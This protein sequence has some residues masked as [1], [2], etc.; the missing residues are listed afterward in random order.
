MSARQLR[1][2]N[3]PRRVSWSSPVEMD[4]GGQRVS[5]SSYYSSSNHDSSTSSRSFSLRQQQRKSGKH[6]VDNEDDDNSSICQ[7]KKKKEKQESKERYLA[8]MLSLAVSLLIAMIVTRVY[9]FSIPLGRNNFRLGT[10]NPILRFRE[11]QVETT[12]KYTYPE[13]KF[14]I[15]QLADLHLGESTAK[16]ERTYKLIDDILKQEYPVDLIV[17]SGDQISAEYCGDANCGTDLYYE[18][19]AFL[20][21]YRIPW[22]VVFGDT[23]DSKTKGI[24]RQQLLNIDQSFEY[25]LSSST[26][27]TPYNVRNLGVAQIQEEQAMQLF[28]TTN[29]LLDIYVPSSIDTKLTSDTFTTSSVNAGTAAAQIYFFDSGGGSL[30]KQLEQNQVSWFLHTNQ[31]L[32]AIAFQHIPTYNFR[33]KTEKCLGYHDAK[34]DSMFDFTSS[35]S[36]ANND[37]KRSSINKVLDTIEYDPGIADAMSESTRISFLAAGHSH[38]NHYCCPFSRWMQ[39]CLGARTGYGGYGEWERGA[40]IY[41]LSMED[42][43]SHKLE[44]KSWV[45]M[46]SGDVYDQVNHYDLRTEQG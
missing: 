23:D 34:V 29:Y 22:A 4:V 6:H 30:P 12:L 7:K 17:L 27:S 2:E 1:G 18:L 14:K 5:R 20:S 41:E 24:T 8:M 38:G 13:Y 10:S 21:T 19:G 33:Y 3:G 28:G 39:V 40:R 43:A 45:R 25:S 37:D 11:E 32:P 36:I 42:P 35:K 46:E 44:W 15:V 9:N 31:R 26:G 16:D